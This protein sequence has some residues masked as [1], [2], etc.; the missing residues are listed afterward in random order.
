RFD[1]VLPFREPEAQRRDVCAQ[2][3]LQARGKFRSRGRFNPAADPESSAAD[4]HR[5]QKWPDPELLRK[6]HRCPRDPAGDETRAGLWSGGSHCFTLGSPMLL[7]NG[8]NHA[9][10]ILRRSRH[11]QIERTAAS[12][13]IPAM[14]MK[15]PGSVFNMRRSSIA[16]KTCSN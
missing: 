15:Y 12:T 6:D 10:L 11:A 5:T 16:L 14:D 9:R 7:V 8:E 13:P 3:R 2:H 1:V 4:D